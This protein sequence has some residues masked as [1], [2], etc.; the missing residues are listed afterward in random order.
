MYKRNNF[1]KINSNERFIGFQFQA[2]IGS[3]DKS[4]NN[5]PKHIEVEPINQLVFKK[6]K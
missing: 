4:N 3:I 1:N 6:R 2:V 5:W